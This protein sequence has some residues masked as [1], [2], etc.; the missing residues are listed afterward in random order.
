MVRAALLLLCLGALCNTT[1][2]AD[3]PTHAAVEIYPSLLESLARAAEYPLQIVAYDGGEA[4]AVLPPKGRWALRE[5]GHLRKLDLFLKGPSDI[6]I[7]FEAQSEGLARA[8]PVARV[9]MVLRGPAEAEWWSKLPLQGDWGLVRRFRQQITLVVR[10]RASIAVSPTG[11]D[12]LS[13]ALVFERVQGKD[14]ELNVRRCP[15][16]LDRIIETHFGVAEQVNLHVGQC[17]APRTRVNVPAV[18][19]PY[20]SRPVTIKDLRPSVRGDVLRIE[21]TVASQ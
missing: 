17:V 5:Y 1:A 21:M 12:G 16:W 18:N 11:G 4:S 3:L 2:G 10:L 19:V 8:R 6:S 13:L 7:A 9:Q 20:L 14:V 15:P